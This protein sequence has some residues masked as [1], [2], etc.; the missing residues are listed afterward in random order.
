[1]RYSELLAR[2]HAELEA[3]AHN[4]PSP[5]APSETPTAGAGTSTDVS[6]PHVAF[7]QSIGAWPVFPDTLAALTTLSKHFALTVLSNVD[8]ASFAHTQRALEGAPEAPRFRF[9]AVYTAEDAGAYKPDPRAREYA[10]RRAE[11]EL[12]VKRE[13]VLV[14]AVSVTHDIKPSREIGLGTA[15]IARK[16]S[17]IGWDEEEGRKAT[18]VFKTLGDMAEAVEREAG[19]A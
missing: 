5:A 3:R 7:G 17:V 14:V 9:A 2:V 4:R 6:D 11:A 16:G 19:G 15:W 1:M 13:E 18:W 10:L 8:R 12:G